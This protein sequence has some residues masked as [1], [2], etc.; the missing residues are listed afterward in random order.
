MAGPFRIQTVDA[1]MLERILPLIAAYQIFY[2][3]QPD[4][5]RNRVF[6]GRFAGGT[7]G[8]IQFVALDDAGE[9]LGYATL[10]FLPSSLSGADYCYLSDLFTIPEAR[11]GG[12][13][14]ALLAHASEHAAS[15]GFSSVEWLTARSNERAQRLYDSLPTHKSEWFYYALPTR[16]AS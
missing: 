5:A 13:A 11:S 10:Y 15:R 1:E 3:Q 12:V 9:P 16:A 4:T 8:G 6:F 2:E 7:P 14:R